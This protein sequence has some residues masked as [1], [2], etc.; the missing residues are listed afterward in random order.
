[1]VEPLHFSDASQG[2][3]IVQREQRNSLV[4]S[5]LQNV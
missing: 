4:E 5:L 2:D 1:V 3:D